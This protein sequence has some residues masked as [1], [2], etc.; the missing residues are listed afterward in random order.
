[1]P[2][3]LASGIRSVGRAESRLPVEVAHAEAVVAHSSLSTVRRHCAHRPAARVRRPAGRRRAPARAAASCVGGDRR[4]A[5]PRARRP[6]R[7]ARPRTSSRVG[8]RER[9]RPC[10]SR[11]GTNV[12][13]EPHRREQVGRAE[14]AAAEPRVVDEDQVAQGLRPPTTRRSTLRCSMPG[15]RPQPLDRSPPSRRAAAAS[16][17]AARPGSSERISS[18]TGWRRSSSAS[19]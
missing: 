19:T 16:P 4:R 3:T 7:R 18:R 10:S 2:S 5:R 11:S 14:A 6:A 8:S 1:M 17:R 13:P 12:G 9:S 15:R